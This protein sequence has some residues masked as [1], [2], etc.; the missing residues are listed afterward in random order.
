MH[1]ALTRTANCVD[2]EVA[3]LPDVL[4]Q[5]G[6]SISVDGQLGSFLKTPFVSR[7]LAAVSLVIISESESLVSRKEQV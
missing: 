5:I 2:A 3:N 4:S 6:V 7:L 1:F